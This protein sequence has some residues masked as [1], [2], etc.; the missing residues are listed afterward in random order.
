MTQKELSY[1]EDAIGHEK[2]IIAIGKNSQTDS[3]YDIN[4]GNKLK[5]NAQTNVWSGKIEEAS[6]AN[7]ATNAESIPPLNPN[8]AR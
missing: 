7:V 5:H 4:I 8:T 1:V 6:T 2:N 3:N